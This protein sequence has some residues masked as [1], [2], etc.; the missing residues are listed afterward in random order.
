[1]KLKQYSAYRDSSVEWIG[2]IPEHWKLIPM[3]IYLESIVDFRVRTPKIQD[4]GLFLVTARNIKNGKINYN[5][6]DE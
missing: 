5:L 6:S 4:Q 2:K 3:T 1:M